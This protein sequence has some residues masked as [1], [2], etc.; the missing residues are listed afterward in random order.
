VPG[1]GVTDGRAALRYGV[2]LGVVLVVVVVVGAAGVGVLLLELEDDGL[3]A[4]VPC[5]MSSRV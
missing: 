4:T 3:G 5:G 2:L 1:V